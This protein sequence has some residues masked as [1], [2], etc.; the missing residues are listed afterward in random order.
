MSEQTGI[1]VDRSLWLTYLGEG[2]LAAGQAM[3]SKDVAEKALMLAR[4][5]GE[6]GHEASALRLLGVIQTREGPVASDTARSTLQQA[7]AL[8]RELGLRPLQVRCHHALGMV[9]ALDDP[10]AAAHHTNLAKLLAAEMAL[11]R[12]ES[13]SPT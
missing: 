11:A 1:I 9:L 7:L 4:S 8:S 10:A 3:R 2:Y 6:R 12:P 5:R 13:P